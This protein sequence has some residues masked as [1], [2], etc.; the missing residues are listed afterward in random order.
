MQ[1]RRLL[2]LITG[3]ALVTLYFSAGQSTGNV[4]AQTPPPCATPS[5]SANGLQGAWKKDAAVQVNINPDQFTSVEIECLRT[6]FTNWNNAAASNGNA[7]G[8]MFT[9]ASSASPVA[10]MSANGSNVTGGNNVYQV[11]RQAPSSPLA[12]ALT[13]GQSDG[14]N[15]TNAVTHIHPE[16]NICEALTET[17]AH[18]IGHTFGLG[19][20]TGSGCNE[21]GSSVMNTLPCG[22]TQNGVCIAP[23]YNDTSRTTAGPTQCDNDK[24]KE[25]G[26]YSAPTPTP[27]P[28]PTPSPSPTPINFCAGVTCTDGCIPKQPNGDCPLGYA[29]RS[30]CCCCKN[31]PTPIVVDIAGNG[32]N[33]TSNAGGAAF[34]LDSDGTDEQLSWTSAG[35][36][37]AWLA[38]DRNGNGRIDNGAELFGNFTPQPPAEDA[39]GF[40]A[41][42]E[43]DKTQN[44]GNGDGR[45]DRRDAIFPSLLLWQDT[46]HN[47]ISEPGELQPLLSLDVKAIDLDYRESRKVDQYGNQFKYR[48]KVYDRRGASVGRWAWDVFL[49]KAP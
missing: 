17:M 25:V 46:N 16:V 33:L 47:G 43:Y 12:A 5:P 31:P 34:D 24:A 26:Q 27:T 7:S 4:D 30:R 3:F 28:V 20:C 15:R 29:G 6:A 1:S 36:D 44:G 35:S 8:V 23:A 38:L 18:E 48:A 19:H 21:T 14:T 37:D 9:I 39:N 22:A 49:R 40:L 2:L 41:L 13:N 11:N 42:S 10:S 32:F 45:I